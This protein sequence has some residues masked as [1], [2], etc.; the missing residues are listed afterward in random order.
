M[1]GRTPV[2]KEEESESAVSKYAMVDSDSE[3]WT[4]H[5]LPLL[6]IDLSTDRRMYE[7]V[8][9]TKTRKRVGN[10]FLAFCGDE[11]DAFEWTDLPKWRS[12]CSVRAR[13]ARV[14]NHIS[15]SRCHENITVIVVIPQEN[16]S[17]MYT[18]T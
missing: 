12:Y 18:R 14:S 10:L 8:M 17:K 16:H 9:M 2:H 15:I 13:S 11:D 3:A 5:F 4:T 1:A 6:K 7:R